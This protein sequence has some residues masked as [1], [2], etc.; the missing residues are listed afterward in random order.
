MVLE[1]NQVNQILR[2]QPIGYYVGR[3]VKVTLKNCNSSYYSIS[4][5]EIVISYPQI[6]RCFAKLSET[7]D[8][9]DTKTAIR[10]IRTV[11]YHEVGH[12]M[13]TPK[14]LSGVLDNR[15]YNKDYYDAFNIFED[16]RIEMLLDGYIKNVNFK[17]VVSLTN[18]VGKGSSVLDK[19]FDLVRFNIYEPTWSEKVDNLLVK[20]SIVVNSS[21]YYMTS[22][23]I[24]KF[25][26]LYTE[27]KDAHQSEENSPNNQDDNDED[28]D[29]FN[30]NLDT[31]VSKQLEQELEKGN[32]Q[33]E[34]SQ[35]AYK[36][37]RGILENLNVEEE[38][39]N[40]DELICEVA[41]EEPK[42]NED[43]S[44]N[45][46]PAVSPEVLFKETTEVF[47]DNK[48][49]Q[50]LSRIFNSVNKVHKANSS[51]I[52]SYS[53]VIDPRSAGRTD[54][55]MFL[56]RNR[57]GNARSFSKVHLNLFLDRSGSFYDNQ[58]KANQIIYTL[59]KIEKMNPNFSYTLITIGETPRIEDKKN[60]YFI[61]DGGNDLPDTVP[62][63]FKQV[64][65]RNYINYNLVL[66]DGGACYDSSNYSNW[67]AF[68]TDNTLIISDP[69]NRDKIEEY[70]PNARVIITENYTDELTSNIIKV[71][72][73]IVR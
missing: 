46:G 8:S 64:Q 40:F 49:F 61:A 34:I 35:D 45:V 39:D 27:Y 23:Y 25:F 59:S 14:E 51:A 11:L 26:D 65:E 24:D 18:T 53:G 31:N 55:R 13:L 67:G 32:S 58:L 52:N 6:V 62:L 37:I 47:D 38:L 10:I 22:R 12:S 43:N 50:E 70:C 68:N 30:S 16:E 72:G 17:E 2:R 71:L 1:F 9:I 44:R 60:I 48:L 42:N 41:N 66:F 33:D 15:T 5:D 36:M 28:N 21:D 54:K 57:E 7:D 69:E 56:Q 63:V 3:S 20:Y 29:S 19:F 4:T 73:S